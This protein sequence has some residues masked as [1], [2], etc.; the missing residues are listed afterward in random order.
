[1]EV[2]GKNPQTHPI[3]DLKNIIYDV[4][5]NKF[6]DKRTGNEYTDADFGRLAETESA[7]QNG[8]GS[9]TLKRSALVASALESA[10]QG[11]SDSLVAGI[12][13]LSDQSLDSPLRK[14]LYQDSRGQ[15]SP[16]TGTIALLKNADLT[17]YLH[18]LGHHFLEMTADMAS[19][20]DVP[21]AVK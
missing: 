9:N 8:A 1:M 17:T 4:A 16:D 18:E 2:T 14:I 3:D 13:K 19:R 6:I 11:T 5:S 7:R 10:S 12:R 21:D 15:Y 20:P